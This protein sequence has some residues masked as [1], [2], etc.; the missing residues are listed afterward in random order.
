M[1]RAY[2]S[3]RGIPLCVGDLRASIKRQP[4]PY[5]GCST[6]ERKPSKQ[7]QCSNYVTRVMTVAM[8]LCGLENWALVKRHGRRIEILE[9]N[10]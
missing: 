7:Q 8:L 5:L 9:I 2:R 1:R 4:K 10:P 3:L 6:T